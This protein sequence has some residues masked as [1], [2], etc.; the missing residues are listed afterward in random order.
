ME[1]REPTFNTGSDHANTDTGEV[2][3]RQVNTQPNS[4]AR[5]T[6]AR[7]AVASSSS[8]SLPTIALV[9]GLIAAAGAGFLGWQLFQ[10]QQ[11]LQTSNDRIAALE[12]QLNVSAEG[13]NQTVT[14]LGARLSKLADAQTKL[15]ADLE[16]QRKS[17]AA[18]VEKVAAQIKETATVKQ[19]ANEAKNSLAA[20]KQEV[21]GN[22]SLVDASLAKIEPGFAQ[23]EQKMDATNEDINKIELDMAN[24]DGLDRRLRATEEA[25]KAIDDFRRTTNRE[26]LQLKQQAGATPAPK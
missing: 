1:R 3:R 13:T 6:Q 7:P 2:A 26:I 12:Q 5:R 4:D 18:N 16:A 25:I 15:T 17:L 24:L 20:L 14:S 11:A 8:S 10:A 19:T 9:V 22:K 21:E 23:L